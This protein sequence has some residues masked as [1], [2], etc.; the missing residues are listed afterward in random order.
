M[1]QGRLLGCRA[2][3]AAPT[4]RCSTEATANLSCTASLHSQPQLRAFR[5]GA[6]PVLWHPASLFPT[7]SPGWKCQRSSTGPRQVL[8]SLSFPQDAAR[9]PQP[10]SGAVGV[11]HTAG[12]LQPPACSA[13]RGEEQRPAQ[14][15]CL[16]TVLSPA[17]PG[18]REPEG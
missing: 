2:G 10:R 9:E 8:Q 16:P 15:C 3:A 4:H 1:Q 18:R 6:P 12:S 14:S 7:T 17:E 5:A 13:P 11:P